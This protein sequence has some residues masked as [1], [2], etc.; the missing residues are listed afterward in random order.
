MQEQ[1]LVGFNLGLTKIAEYAIGLPTKEKKSKVPKVKQPTT[2]EYSVQKHEAKRA[3]THYDLRLGNPDTG[4][5]HSWALRYLPS[6][7][8]ITLAVKQPDHTLNYMDYQGRIESGYG[9]GDVK[10]HSRNTAEITDAT[11]SKIN[12]NVYDGKNNLEYTLVKTLEDK[13]LLLNR[14][15]KRSK[16]IPVKRP[17]Y[18][19]VK[20]D[21]VDM[22]NTDQLMS[23][24]DDGA[25]AL[26]ILKGNSRLKVISPRIGQNQTGILDYTP[27][28]S[29]VFQQRVPMS[30]DDT[31][32]R[33][34]IFGIDKRREH[35]MDASQ[36]AGILNAGVHKSRDKQEQLG[37]L[38]PTIFDVV[39]YRGQSMANAPYSEKLK[40]LQRIQQSLPQLQIPEYAVSPEDKIDLLTRMKMGKIKESKE[41][42]VLWD[43]VNP[44]AKPI[45]VKFRPDYDVYIRN[46]FMEEGERQGLA[47]GFAYSHTPEGP[48]VGR[49]GTGFTHKLKK[50]MADTPDK[51][52][53]AAAKV[54]ALGRYE[55]TGA[56]RAP[57]FK[58]FH[59]EKGKLVTP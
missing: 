49:V 26:Y 13:Y 7:G 50:E 52:I 15:L 30:L 56:L 3:G 45:K 57:A 8:E 4:I 6:P 5:A 47:G 17:A 35:S 58:S 32:L 25:H 33:G 48:I 31:I 51:F 12:F 24:K 18:T 42:V 28:V 39:K 44:K 37:P 59:Q 1:I 2:W 10:L 14:T 11:D 23:R 40:I 34:E 9:T 16:E 53:G 46:I 38:L 20:E 41:G 29:S 43:L 55:D 22:L 21:D 54:E 19:E 27:R 36:V